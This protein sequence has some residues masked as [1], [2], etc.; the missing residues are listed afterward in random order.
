MSG[1]LMLSSG[2][3]FESYS[4]LEKYLELCPEK[5]RA[6]SVPNSAD[7]EFVKY[8]ASRG[9]VPLG[10][11]LEELAERFKERLDPDCCA[12]AA[13]EVLNA[14]LDE[15]QAVWLLAKQL[16]GWTLEIAEALGV[17]KLKRLF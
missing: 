1:R 4:L 13:R 17:V 7:V 6:E 9:A 10:E 11:L 16:A 15:D 3:V 2:R 8:A 14:E 5:R 12:R